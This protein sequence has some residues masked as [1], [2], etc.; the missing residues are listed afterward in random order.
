MNSYSQESKKAVANF[1]SE[2]LLIANSDI[3]I[4]SGKLLLQ[5]VCG[6]NLKM[7]NIYLFIHPVESGFSNISPVEEMIYNDFGSSIGASGVIIVKEESKLTDKE[8]EEKIS[9]LDR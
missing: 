2:R 3:A 9:S 4:S 1:S 7:S 6:S 5:E 8:I